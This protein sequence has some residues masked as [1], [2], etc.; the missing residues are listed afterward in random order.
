MSDKKCLS[1]NS[2]ERHFSRLQLCNRRPPAIERTAKNYMYHQW[3][4]TPF[5]AGISFGRARNERSAVVLQLIELVTKQYIASYVSRCISPLLRLWM[6]FPKSPK[7]ST[8][9]EGRSNISEL[10]FGYCKI[11]SGAWKCNQKVDHDC[12]IPNY[13]RVTFF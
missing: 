10:L 1:K 11:F 5:L 13:I 3:K 6:H 7:V 9:N 4:I 8:P 2:H 12:N